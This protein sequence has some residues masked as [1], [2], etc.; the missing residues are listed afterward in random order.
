MSNVAI[1]I[2]GLGKKY[3]IGGKQK[4]YNRLGDQVAAAVSAPFRRAGNLLRGQYG[5]ASDLDQEFWALKDISVEIK[6]GEII[7]IIG[8]NGAG[9]STLLKILSQITEPTTGYADVFGRVGSLLEVGTGFHPE[10][11]GRENVYLNG[12]ILGMRRSE[13]DRKFDAIVDFAEI[14]QFIDTPVKHYSSGMYVRLAFSVAAHLEPEILL[15]DEVLAVGD[16]GFQKKSLGKM[17]NVSQQGRTV[18]FVSHNM[19]ALQRLC[20]QSIL[21]SHGRLITRDST[22]NVIEQYLSAVSSESS[23]PNCEI[24]LTNQT[25][26]ENGT[27]KI[28]FN[29]ISYA[30]DN[31]SLGYYPYTDGPLEISFSMIAQSDCSVGSVA[32]IVF[33]RYGTKL[34]NADTLAFGQPIEL[35]K[36][37]NHL[38][39]RID[40]LHLNPGLYT[41]GLW[42]AD[43]PSE[44]YD[45]IPSAALFEVIE[46]EKENIR[47]KADGLVPVKF[48]LVN[49]K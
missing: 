19:N 38:K 41:L 26:N 20:P 28:K 8:H 2:E 44:V 32:V 25:R 22:G 33:D 49:S 43:P 13:I 45:Y 35:H 37:A 46:A 9:K 24:D 12:S 6:H 7:G 11:T 27:G 21:L 42:V 14:E 40:Q 36:G 47:V 5:S 23:G 10:L 17:E 15:I 16:V 31:P 29:S 39:L 4:R 18:V 1:R 34:V 3:H 48:S 30:G